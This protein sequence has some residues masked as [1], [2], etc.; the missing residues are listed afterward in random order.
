MPSNKNHLFPR[1]FDHLFPS[2]FEVSKLSKKIFYRIFSITYQTIIKV[3]RTST[4]LMFCNFLRF[5]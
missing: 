2:W 3:S 1:W 4:G 5:D